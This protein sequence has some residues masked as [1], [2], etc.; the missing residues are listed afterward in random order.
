MREM[1]TMILIE[2]NNKILNKYLIN[3]NFNQNLINKND[4]IT[5]YLL[6]KENNLIIKAK[7]DKYNKFLNF[8]IQGN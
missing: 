6:N 5:K 4:I 2:F 8:F 3:Y 7:F 1:I